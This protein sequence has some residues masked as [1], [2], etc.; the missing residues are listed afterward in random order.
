M[1]VWL[2]GGGEGKGEGIV[3]TDPSIVL[4]ANKASVFS[5]EDFQEAVGNMHIFAPQSPTMWL[6]MDGEGTYTTDGT[7]VYEESLKELI[8]HYKEE[9]GAEK[10]ILAG[11]SNGGY[12][13][14]RMA[15]LYPEDYDA[16]IPI[17]HGYRSEWLTDEQLDSIKN[18]PMFFIYADSDEVLIPAKNSI[19]VI[20]R[21][22]DLGA[23]EVK[24]SSTDIVEDTSGNYKGE[25]GNPYL[26]NGH[27][28]WIYF[29]NNESFDN[30]D[31][32]AI[33]DWIKIQNDD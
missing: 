16:L 31:N 11:P 4:L 7:S 13:T 28:S 10:V 14:L 8:D 30:D 33:F 9:V 32:T 5:T 21:L 2:H 17:C 6:D 20:Q 26:Y 3:G 22:R 23:E 29:F 19:P 15:V 12:M 24:V 25:D 27:W 18:I 1:L